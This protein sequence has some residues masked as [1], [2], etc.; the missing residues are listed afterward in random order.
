MRCRSVLVL[1]AIALTPSA[2]RLDGSAAPSAVVHESVRRRLDETGQVNIVVSVK[3]DELQNRVSSA[4]KQSRRRLKAATTPVACASDGHVSDEDSATL[5]AGPSDEL[6]KHVVDQLKQHAESQHEEILAFL[7]S[8]ASSSSGFNEREPSYSTAKSLWIS[9]EVVVRNVTAE[10]VD[11]LSQLTSVAAIRPEAVGHIPVAA[12]VNA[13]ASGLPGDLD[14][15]RRLAQDLVAEWSVERVAVLDAWRSGYFG[16]G[17]R[18]AT[19]DSGVRGSH[20]SL[21]ANFLGEYGWYD[22]IGTAAAPEDSSGHGTGV[23]G[24]L[25]GQD[26]LGVAPLAQW[27][28]CRACDASN[29][30]QEGDLL[31]CAQFLTCPTLSTTTTVATTCAARPHVINN[32][33]TLD[34]GTSSF[35]SV[36]AVWTAAGIVSVFAAGNTG[37]SCST[38]GAPA[39]RDSGIAVGSTD[40]SNQVSS[41]SAR[42]PGLDGNT[43]PDVVAPGETI[44]SSGYDS[45]ASLKLFSG[46]SIAAPHVSGAVALLME[47][48]PS[49]SVDAIRVLLRETA[50]AAVSVPST[51]TTSPCGSDT[52]SAGVLSVPN[53]VFGYG[54]VNVSAALSRQASQGNATVNL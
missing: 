31:E 18:V 29:D 37:P 46:T 26:G 1:L 45:D 13:T 14:S 19:I 12:I 51:Q 3:G 35:E 32:S 5:A 40:Y 2:A 25:V 43:K 10:L 6:V 33:W 30:C 28:T 42:G 16:N 24:V 20:S 54:I 8:N 34:R 49:L 4:V 39:D 53:N 11:Q 15:Q 47:A 41:F 50:D 52:V 23:M 17:T 48:F 22:A 38:V 36:V 44:V 27:M 21:S 7:Q 9:N